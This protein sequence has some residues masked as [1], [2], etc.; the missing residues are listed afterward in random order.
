MPR[1]VV[2]ATEG[3]IIGE[4]MAGAGLE[5]GT[6]AGTCI[7]NAEEKKALGIV[8]KA[9][10]KYNKQLPRIAQETASSYTY[11]PYLSCTWKNN[12]RQHVNG[13]THA[14]V[15]YVNTNIGGIAM[16]VPI[17]NVQGST[18]TRFE[19]I[20]RT[21]TV[22][23]DGSINIGERI[24]L[25]EEIENPYSKLFNE[26]LSQIRSTY[27]PISFMDYLK[28][29]GFMWHDLCV[30]VSP[31][32]C[33]V[34]LCVNCHSSYKKSIQEYAIQHVRTLTDVKL[35]QFWQNKEREAFSRA[36]N[37]VKERIL[38]LTQQKEEENKNMLQMFQRFQQ[39]SGD[40]PLASS[41]N[42]S[43]SNYPQSTTA[44]RPM[45]MI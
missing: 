43:W 30:I 25:N 20:S 14:T 44:P 36:D 40:V 5:V 12:E 38:T 15:N 2:V 41:S 13:E 29:R 21:L 26:A 9:Q 18:W 35:D 11:P 32:C 17:S 34:I 4:A 33:P 19:L 6:G 23:Y 45:N 31:I 42:N 16:R 7:R 8:T 10:T 39:Q 24:I 28:E 1:T 3:A 37:M 27:E 22:K